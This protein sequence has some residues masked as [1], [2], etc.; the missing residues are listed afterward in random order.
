MNKLAI[1]GGT[2]LIDKPLLPYSSLDESDVKAVADVMKSGR[3]SEFIGAWCDEF[4]GGPLI[5]E[6]E[7]LWCE[8]FKCKHSISVN[9]NTSGLIAAMGA[10]GLSPGEEVIVPPWTMSATAM[11][12]LFYGG[13][14][15]F[16]DIENDYFCLDV[17]SVE[18]KLNSNT[19]AIIAVNLFGH[20]AELKKLRDLADKNGIYLIE[21]NAQAPHAHENGQL[22]GVIGHIGVASLNYHKHIHTGEGGVCTT[23]DDDLAQRLQLIRNHGENVTTDLKIDN[24]ANLIGFNFRMTE[25][26]AA[27]G[28]SQI[29]KSKL[30]VD[31]RVEVSDILT[32]RLRGLDGL[33]VPKV[34]ENCKHVYYVWSAKLDLDLLGIDRSLIVKALEA[35]GC[36]VGAGYVEPLYNLPTFQKKIAIG[37]NGFPFTLS[38]VNYSQSHCKNK[39]DIPCS[40]CSCAR[41]CPN[42]EE[43]HQKTLIEFFPCS[44]QLDGQEIDLIADCYE[45]VF[46]NLDLLRSKSLDL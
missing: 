14:P 30:L 11:A 24:I 39:S 20:P 16:A 18:A 17:K 43:L 36:P 28:I 9:S 40:S 3:I 23:N 29:K 32:N 6:F 25:I 13:I 33:I 1:L 5:K 10:I 41:S 35:E 22:T 21:D 19:K 42:I 44:F 26:G 7:K 38:D 46:S 15:V 8:E 12:P 4:Y 37:N 2:P 31:R 34:R 27:I 45:K